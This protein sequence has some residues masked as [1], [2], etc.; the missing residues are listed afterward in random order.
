M[1]K[2]DGAHTGAAQFP[3]FLT[4]EINGAQLTQIK[5]PVTWSLAATSNVFYLFCDA[6]HNA[7]KLNPGWKIR[8]IQLQGPDWEWVA[9]PRSGA[10]T[11]SFSVR[12]HARKEAAAHTKVLFKGLTLEGPPGAMDWRAAFP[13]LKAAR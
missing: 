1:G 3:N 2:R 11:A 7:V 13:A 4:S 6:S 9:C 5:P 10:N 8:G 12:L